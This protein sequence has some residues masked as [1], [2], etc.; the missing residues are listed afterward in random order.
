[1]PVAADPAAPFPPMRKAAPTD[2][3]PFMDGGPLVSPRQQRSQ[4]VNPA[5]ISS[6]TAALVVYTSIAEI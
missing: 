3:P 5:I 4:N 6:L 2:A 1:M